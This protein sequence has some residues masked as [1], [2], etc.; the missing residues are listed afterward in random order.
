M[1][2][3]QNIENV[4]IAPDKNGI[5]LPDVIDLQSDPYYHVLFYSEPNAEEIRRFNQF[6]RRNRSQKIRL[7]HGTKSEIPAMS[8]GL[9]PSSKKRRNSLQSATGY[10]CFSV[11]KEMAKHFGE[12]AFPG[13]SITVYAIE[14]SFS[15]LLPDKDQLRNKRMWTGIECGDTLGESLIIGR[16][17]RVKGHIPPYLIY[18]I[19]I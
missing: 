10:V 16:G 14:Y 7:Y 2:E 15:M 11:Y 13:K 3:S 6:I 12:M 18:P 9:K 5:K 4:W 19:K 1:K 17:A 8:E